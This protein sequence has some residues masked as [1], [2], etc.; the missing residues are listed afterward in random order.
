MNKRITKKKR[1]QEL[2]RHFQITR[3]EIYHINEIIREGNFLII[4]AYKEESK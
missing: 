2:N 1:M 4:K 3:K